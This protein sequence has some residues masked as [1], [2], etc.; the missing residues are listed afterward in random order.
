MV[1]IVVVHWGRGRG[2]AGAGAGGGAGIG[3]GH[4][5]EPFSHLED[6]HLRG[7]ALPAHEFVTGPSRGRPHATGDLCVWH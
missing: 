4:C 2:E 1:L 5:V 6:S 7:N 3:E